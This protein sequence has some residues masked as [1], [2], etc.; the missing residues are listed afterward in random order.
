MVSEDLDSNAQTEWC[1]C[2]FSSQKEYKN[3]ISL[4]LS[5]NN[6]IY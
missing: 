5:H 6:D 4:D 1:F 2:H 3:S